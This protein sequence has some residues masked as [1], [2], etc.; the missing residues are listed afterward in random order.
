MD[1]FAYSVKGVME[2][3]SENYAI[4]ITAPWSRGDEI[5]ENCQKEKER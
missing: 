2:Y 5:S 3:G 1:S 4:E